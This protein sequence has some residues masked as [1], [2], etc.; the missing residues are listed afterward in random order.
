MR[1]TFNGV[2]GVVA[3][4]MRWQKRDQIQKPLGCW[5][6]RS[7]AVFVENSQ[8]LTLTPHVFCIHFI[9]GVSGATPRQ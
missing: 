5:G 7:A 9:G 3:F 2:L 8:Q 1:G 6:I 4:K